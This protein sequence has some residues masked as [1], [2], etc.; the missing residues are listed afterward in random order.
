MKNITKYLLFII[1]SLIG[2]VG[3]SKAY[4]LNPNEQMTL[5]TNDEEH[6]DVKCDVSTMHTKAESCRWVDYLQPMEHTD[7]DGNTN[8]YYYRLAYK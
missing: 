6:K 2:F 7:I 1:F 5:M 8:T 4:D 3:V